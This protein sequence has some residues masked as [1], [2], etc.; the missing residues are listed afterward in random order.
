M[1]REKDLFLLLIHAFTGISSKGFRGMGI[2]KPLT[3]RAD[4]AFLKLLLP[5]HRSAFGPA[6]M[7]DLPLFAELLQRLD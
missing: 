5:R 7:V 4:S 3:G 1:S 6:I 2:H